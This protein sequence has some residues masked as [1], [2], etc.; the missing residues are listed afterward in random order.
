MGR[1]NP[2][3]RDRLERLRADWSDYRRALRRRDEP[4]FDRLF[5][6]A[7]AHA[8]ACGYLNH[9]SPIVPVLLSVALEQQ[10]TIAALEERVAALEAAEDDS[11]REVDA[12]QTAIERPWPGGVDE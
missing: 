1:T 2:T 5:E 8:D 12:C 3:F 11:G 6:H 7:R 9:D 10:A 4:H